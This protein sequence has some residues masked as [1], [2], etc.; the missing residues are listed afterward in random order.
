MF[1]NYTVVKHGV[2]S[3]AKKQSAITAYDSK[4]ILFD[5]KQIIKIKL[6]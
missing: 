6:F 1:I 2:L 3:E 4:I 5:F